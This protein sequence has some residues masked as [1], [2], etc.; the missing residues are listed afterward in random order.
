MCVAMC[1]CGKKSLGKIYNSGSPPFPFSSTSTSSFTTPFLT[2]FYP[3]ICIT[4]RAIINVNFYNT[5]FWPN[6]W[7]ILLPQTL[8][9]ALVEKNTTFLDYSLQSLNTKWMTCWCLVHNG[10]KLR[11]KAKN[12]HFLI[13]LSSTNGFMFVHYVNTFFFF[14]SAKKNAI[15]LALMTFRGEYL[16]FRTGQKFFLQQKSSSVWVEME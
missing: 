14:G 8:G 10:E 15:A 2:S 12:F 5:T 6:L 4:I 16:W 11:S 1:I 9:H 13:S 3:K 7:V